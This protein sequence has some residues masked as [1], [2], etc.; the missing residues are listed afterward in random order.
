VAARQGGVVT[1]EQAR[2]CGYSLEEIGRLCADGR[3]TRL[4][5]AVYLPG[6]APTSA[7]DPLH[8]HVLDAA[9]ALL[10]LEGRDAVVAHTS[11][12][13]LWG[14]DFIEQKPTFPEVLLARPAPGAV[15]R[16]PGLRVLPAALPDG[17]VTI[18]PG[19]L[20]TCTAARVVVDLARRSPARDVVVFGDSA[21]R[22][23]STTRAELERV[24]VDCAGWPGA[25]RAAR[26]LALLDEQAESP[27]ESLTR[28]T[29]T[30]GGLTDVESQVTIRDAGGRVIARVDFLV[31]RRVAVEPDGR[32][33]YADPDALWREKLRFPEPPSPASLV[34]PGPRTPHGTSQAPPGRARDRPGE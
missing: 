24:L 11:G 34:P 31:A 12:A 14:L 18:G 29:L 5:R 3:W 33:K 22:R 25:R 9:A 13:A 19:G 26:L 6:P 27:A 4:R 7:A 10:S 23:R 2:T 17:H 32:I 8:R 1:L 21:L 28:L 15:R 30:A 16:Y 20:R